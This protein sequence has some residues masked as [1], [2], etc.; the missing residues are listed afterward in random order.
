MIVAAR[1]KINDPTYMYL[2]HTS[3][4]YSAFCIIHFSVICDR[5]YPVCCTPL[6]V[7]S[8]LTIPWTAK[9]NHHYDTLI[10]IRISLNNFI[11]FP[12]KDGHMYGKQGLNPRS[13][14]PIRSTLKLQRN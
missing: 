9:S 12:I 7:A 6:D 11:G 5:L 4:I 8:I 14:F 10:A 13:V 2:L 3:E 1:D